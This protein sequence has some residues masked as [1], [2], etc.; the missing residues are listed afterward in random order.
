MKFYITTKMS[1]PRTYKFYSLFVINN[2]VS[3]AFKK[4]IKEVEYG[5]NLT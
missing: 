3:V 1:N 2:L 5:L 4:I